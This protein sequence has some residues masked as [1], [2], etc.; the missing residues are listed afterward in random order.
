ME[1][2]KKLRVAGLLAQEVEFI[3]LQIGNSYLPRKE[4]WI[5]QVK[6]ANHC[7]FRYDLRK[8]ID[9][10]SFHLN[11][12]KENK[13]AWRLKFN[14]KMERYQFDPGYVEEDY[15]EF[16][17]ETFV[18]I[19][20]ML[21]EGVKYKKDRLLKHCHRLSFEKG[22]QWKTFRLAFNR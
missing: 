22:G 2:Q 17:Q 7:Q 10:S 9:G 5:T 8:I 1:R 18:F 20:V 16:E 15:E 12:F 19:K 6:L 21:S 4:E 3:G 13:K 11:N 14:K